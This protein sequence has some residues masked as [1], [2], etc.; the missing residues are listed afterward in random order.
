MAGIHDK[1][2]IYIY[3]YGVHDTN[4]FTSGI[5]DTKFLGL[6]STMHNI[7]VWIHDT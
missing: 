2:Y 6:V 1:Y 5:H 4:M 3:V 7:C